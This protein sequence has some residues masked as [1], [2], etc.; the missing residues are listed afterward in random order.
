MKKRGGEMDHL[1][2][3]KFFWTNKEEYL[4]EQYGSDEIILDKEDFVGNVEKLRS[5]IRSA[6]RKCEQG[7]IAPEIE[8]VLSL[9]RSDASDKI[10]YSEFGAYIKTH[11]LS[12]SKLS[13]LAEA[14]PAQARRVLEKLVRDYCA[15]REAE[16]ARRGVSYSSSTLQALYDSGSS[17]KKGR[18]GPKKL[19]A[20]LQKMARFKAV[21]N[22]EE[23]ETNRF[24][25]F[26]V[27][28]GKALIRAILGKHKIRFRFSGKKEDKLPDFC[29]RAG[30]HFFIVEAKHI[31]EP[32]GA[33]DKQIN[34]IIGFIG[35]D[36]A[37]AGLSVHYVSFLDGLYANTFDFDQPPEG[38]KLGLQHAN[39]SKALKKHPANY[40]V[41]TFGFARLVSQFAP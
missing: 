33:Q 32:G 2:F 14:D 12:F 22:M 11:D 16:Y 13:E 6:C 9:I 21:G 35:Y 15:K 36:E 17:R 1:G 29:F 34:E 20:I 31:H 19:S 27:D 3:L 10:Q 30:R 28:S 24:G 41:N 7:G 5:I 25:Y 8:S 39:V 37:A 4:D 18:M 23:F 38:G 40:F 26:E